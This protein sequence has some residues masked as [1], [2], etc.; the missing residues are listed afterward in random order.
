MIKRTACA[1]IFTWSAFQAERGID[2]N[3]FL[4]VRP[5]GNVLIDPME[6]D[7]E[8][9]ADVHAKGGAAWIL[10]TNYDHLRA[11]PRLADVLAAKILAPAG[12][13]ERFGQDAGLVHG[14]FSTSADLPVDLQEEIDVIELRGGKSPI[15]AALFLKE[16]GALVFGDLVR[17]HVSGRLMLL[18]DPKLTDRAM[19]LES[20]AALR[21]LTPAAVLL[22]DGDSFFFRAAEA[23]SEFLDSLA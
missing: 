19:A 3:G 2:F 5:E 21:S 7:Q 9:L 17:S 20:L 11:A 18:P 8:G 13:R 23:F 15:E 12:E 4:W 10:L 14:W 22:G 1:G 6:L 16:P